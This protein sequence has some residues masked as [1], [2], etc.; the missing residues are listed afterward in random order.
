MKIQQVK[1][2]NRDE[3]ID[4]N[5]RVEKWKADKFSHNIIP[6]IPFF[7]FRQR[8]GEMRRKGYVASD[9]NFAYF[10][11]TKKEVLKRYYDNK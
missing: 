1:E 3:L 4:Y 6:Q 10:A 5:E 9:E 7:G 2:Y 8:N 11:K